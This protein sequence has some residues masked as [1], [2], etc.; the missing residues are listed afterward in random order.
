MHV[1]IYLNI[2]A[3]SIYLYSASKGFLQLWGSFSEIH[4]QGLARGPC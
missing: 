4:E 1:C 3:P 2:Q